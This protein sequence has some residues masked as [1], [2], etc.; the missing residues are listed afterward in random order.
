MRAAQPVLSSGLGRNPG[1]PANTGGIIPPQ[2]P[3]LRTTTNTVNNTPRVPPNPPNPNPSLSQ[4]HTPR[5][6]GGTMDEDDGAD[7][8]CF[9]SNSSAVM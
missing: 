4:L 2:A 9:S 1:I 3:T 5:S 8:V 7:V 6:P